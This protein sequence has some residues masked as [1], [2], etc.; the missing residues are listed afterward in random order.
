MSTEQVAAVGHSPVPHRAGPPP[1]GAPTQQQA[2]GAV[3]RGQQ[4][5]QPPGCSIGQ[6]RV[7]CGHDGRRARD[8]VL[9]VVAETAHRNAQFSIAFGP[10]QLTGTHSWGGTD[11]VEAEVISRD[12]SSGGRKQ[13][14]H[15]RQQQPSGWRSG[16]RQSYE[17]P[18]P[19]NQAL[20]PCD[21]NP[22]LHYISGRGCDE[23]VQ[24]VRVLSYPSQQYQL[25]L[26]VALFGDVLDAINR[27]VGEVL[28]RRFGPVRIQP[29]LVQ[30]SG[31]LSVAWGWKEHTDWRAKF[32][33]AVQAGLNPA[34]GYSVEVQVSLLH[35]AGEVG[36]VALGIPQPIADWLMGLATE[37]LADCF[38]F[39]NV[40]LS[41]SLQGH[42][43]V[44]WLAD[45]SRSASGRAG[46]TPSLRGLLRIGMEARAGGD[47]WVS[48]GVRGQVE[49][50]LIG[51]GQLEVRRDGVYLSPELRWPGVT[52]S[53]TFYLRAVSREIASKQMAW[54]P[55]GESTLWQAPRGGWKLAG[56]R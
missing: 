46:I 27:E 4:A 43:A 21:A 2:A 29:R 10:V 1:S 23:A 35:V 7:R 3:Q 25:Q 20:F 45:G 18:A 26:N 44:A 39:W 40:E 8:G 49:T 42:A 13:S 12:R 5:A 30:P 32:E 33:V 34:F 54:Q 6:L 53:V 50:G 37:Y 31:E 55:I 56:N 36:L 14:C 19:A 51:R 48:I 28:D 11:T 41:W 24:T 16:A 22:E 17:I 38:V 9:Q 47:S 52:L 15:H